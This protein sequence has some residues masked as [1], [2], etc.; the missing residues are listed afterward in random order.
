M[1]LDIETDFI[2]PRLFKDIIV[3][4]LKPTSIIKT[5]FKKLRELLKYYN[6]F[7][8]IINNLRTIKY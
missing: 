2:Y 1:D 7:F 6:I 4:K 3:K 8:N 5:L